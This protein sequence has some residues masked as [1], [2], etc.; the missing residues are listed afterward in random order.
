[1]L[2]LVCLTFTTDTV[3]C[4]LSCIKWWLWLL[5]YCLCLDLYNRCMYEYIWLFPCYT[6][7]YIHVPTLLAW[8]ILIYAQSSIISSSN[9]GVQLGAYIRTIILYIFFWFSLLHIDNQNLCLQCHAVVL[10]LEIR[11]IDQVIFHLRFILK[12][13]IMLIFVWWVI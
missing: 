9:M 10:H 5:L 2:V 8:P 11:W 7:S 12:L 4:Y 6:V 1:M 13:I 3:S